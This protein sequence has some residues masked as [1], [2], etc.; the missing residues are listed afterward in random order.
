M[1]EEYIEAPP[2]PG[3]RPYSRTIFVL[4]ALLITLVVGWVLDL[5][6]QV[7]GLNL[8]SEQMLL[9]VLG[10]AIAIC[11]LTTNRNPILDRSA[12]ALGLGLCLYLAV[13]Y[14]QLSNE[15]TMRPLDG[16]LTSAGARGA[17]PRRHAAHGRLLARRLHALRRGLRDARPPP[18]GRVPGAAGRFH[19][20]ARVP[21]PRHQRAARHLAADRHRGG[22]ALHPAR[23]RARPLRRLGVLHRPRARLDG[24]LPRRLGEGRGRRLGVLRHDLG[25]RGGERLARSAW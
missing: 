8:Y 19:A 9:A 20:A 13:R 15:L 16:I 12:A 6:R 23:A 24:A 1:S 4:Q 3:K 25:Q 17:G 11:F 22:G 2:A 21:Q 10:L 7:F 5:Q 18:A 14:P